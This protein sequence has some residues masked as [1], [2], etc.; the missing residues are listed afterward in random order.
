MATFAHRPWEQHNPEPDRTYYTSNALRLFA[1]RLE[2]RREGQVLDMGPVCCENIRFFANRVKRFHVCD[3]FLRLD[4]KRRNSLPLSQAWRHLDYP[5]QSFDGILL[6]ELVDRLD[7]REVK[8]LAD[9]CYTMVKPKGTVLVFVLGEQSA[10][11]TVNT[12]VI[13]DGYQI[14]QRLQPHLDLPLHRRQNREV[15]SLMEPLR[16]IKSF[17]YLHGF[18]EFLFQRN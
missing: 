16:P 6:W 13:R 15:L 10:P 9:L 4:R 7:D 11:P 3:M 17:I 8:R 5:P 12:F 14:Y 18:R 2:R 1:E